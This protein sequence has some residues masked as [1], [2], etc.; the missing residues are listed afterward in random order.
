MDE[1][2]SANGPVITQ[3]TVGTVESQPV[4]KVQA[5]Y[6]RDNPILDDEAFVAGRGPLR[7]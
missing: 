6:H 4:V 3:G 5:I 7:S 2:P 1:G